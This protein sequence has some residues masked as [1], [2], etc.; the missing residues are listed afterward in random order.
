MKSSALALILI[1]FGTAGC[2]SGPQPIS[3][4]RDECAHC[5]MLITDGRFA[6]QLVTDRGKYEKFDS[7]EC[8]LDDLSERS[9]RSIWVSNAVAPG[10][11]IEADKAVFV[12]SDKIRSPMGG[13]I[14]AFGTAEE[15]KSL[16]DV[17][18]LT[19]RQLSAIL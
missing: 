6:A 18:T 3:Q 11:W 9:Y 7:V 2:S 1:L 5:K 15:A 13:G 16:T 8:L 10:Q 19:W 17:R 4:G 12:R 14:A